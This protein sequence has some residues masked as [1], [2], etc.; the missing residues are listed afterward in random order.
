MLK[1]LNRQIVLGLILLILVVPVATLIKP[2]KAEASSY[3]PSALCT[4]GAFINVNTIDYAGVQ[5]WLSQRGSYLA[6]YSVGGYTAAQLIYNASRAYGIN[7]IVIF[8]TLQKEQGLI[9][10]TYSK[11]FDQTRF[12]W[13]MGYGYTDSGP[14][15]QYAGFATQIDYGT[16]QLRQNFNTWAQNGSVWNVGKSMSIDG[17]TITF[18]NRCTSSLYRYTP[19]L[20]GNY[21]FWYYYNAWSGEGYFNAALVAQGPYSGPGVYGTAL[22][23]GQPFTVWASFQNTGNTTWTF[24]DT[25]TPVHLGTWAPADRSSAFLRGQNLRGYMIQDTVAPGEVG[26]FVYDFVAPGQ[27]GNYCERF[28]LVAEYVG[29]IG[30]EISWN[31]TV[32]KAQAGSQLAAQNISQGPAGGPASYGVPLAGGQSAT[33][34]VAALNTGRQTWFRDGA[35]ATYLGSYEPRD[36]G[37]MFTGGQNLRGRLNQGA[38]YPGQIGTFDI[39]ITGPLQAGD[40]VEHYRLV[41]NGVA[42]FGPDF[43]WLLQVR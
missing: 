2:S 36:R 13:A 11:G 19:H 6:N 7:P 15:P 22:L 30:Q 34:S 16:W 12:D 28:R 32:S 37:S 40:F 41:M 38:V 25:I 9:V 8:A 27:A 3:N 1:Y 26:T 39:P 21:L 29:R 23:P 5:Y 35:N 42:W 17:Q 4:D 31:Y 18:A 24:D 20:H 43:S 14:L 33:I 10:G